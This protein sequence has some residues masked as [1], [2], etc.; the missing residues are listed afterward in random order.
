MAKIGNSNYYPMKIQFVTIVNNV[1]IVD[2]SE[3]PLHKMPNGDSWQWIQALINISF[4][5]QWD[6]AT[7]FH[8]QLDG[9][10]ATQNN[11]KRGTGGG[12]D[13]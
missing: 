1:N 6:V 2:I 5:L 9:K 8:S 11:Y 12:T 4:S 13:W 7:S 10:R 3:V